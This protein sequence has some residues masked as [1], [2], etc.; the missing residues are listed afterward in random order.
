MSGEDLQGTG[1]RSCLAIDYKNSEI[2]NYASDSDTFSDN[3]SN[4]T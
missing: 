3:E 1:L 2:I 4:N